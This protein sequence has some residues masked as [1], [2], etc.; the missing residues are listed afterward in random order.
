[1]G[2]TKNIGALTALSFAYECSRR[3]AVVAEPIGDNS[4]YDFIVDNGKQLFRIQVK[5]ASPLAK[6]P[7]TFNVNG[8]R[9]IPTGKGVISVPYVEGE[10][11][12]L[13]TCACGVWFFFDKPHTLRSIVQIRP[14]AAPEDYVWNFG[15]NNWAALGLPNDPIL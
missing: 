7:G 4:R 2:A 11:D 9:K 8:T 15:K 6:L 10:V 14:D 3:G 12:C 13:V 5:T 1:M